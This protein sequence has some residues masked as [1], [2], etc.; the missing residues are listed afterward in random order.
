MSR[1][2][3]YKGV[4]IDM[5][6]MRRE[7][8]KVPAVGNMKVNARGDRIQNG[9]II[10]T[11]DQIARESHRTKAAI[12]KTSLKGPIPAAPDMVSDAKH[13]KVPAKAAEVVAKEVEQ[14]NGDIIIESVKKNEGKST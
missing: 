1:H 2:V 4:T 10:K 8:E 12:V 11:A 3:T 7:N 9:K 6:S 13:K 14:E 5:D